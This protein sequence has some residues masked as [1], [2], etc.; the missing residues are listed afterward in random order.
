MK[1]KYLFQLLTLFFY[2]SPLVLFAQPEFINPIPIPPVLDADSGVIALDMTVT[3]HKFNPNGGGDSLNG[4]NQ[5]G[6]ESW[7]YNKAGE[8]SNTYLGPTLRWHTGDS[9]HIV[10]NNLLPDSTTTHWHGAELPA[11]LD[12]GPH[13][14]IAPGASWYVDIKDLDST[15]TIWYHP[16]LHNMTYEQVQRGLSG[17]IISEQRVDPVRDLLPRTYGVDDIPVIIGDQLTTDTI[18]PDYV[19]EIQTAKSKRPINLVN[20]VTNPYLELPAHVVRLRILNGSSRKAIEFGISDSYSDTALSALQEFYLVASDGGYALKPDTMTRMM[21]GPGERSEIIVDLSGKQVG[22]TV[23][24]RNLKEYLPNYV[25]GSPLLPPQ[26]SGAGG[27]TGQDTTNGQAF[28][29]IR[30]IADPASYTPVTAF[31]AF[32]TTWS[33]EIADTNDIAKYRTKELIRVPGTGFTIDS[34]SYE[35]M[36]INDTVCVDTKEIWTIHNKTAIAHPFHIH[37]IFFRVLEARDSSGTLLNLDS[38]G[39]NAP[40]DDILVGPYTRVRF[41]AAFDD[42]P[43]PIEAENTYMYHCHILTHEDEMG[44]G[45]MHQFVVTNEAPCNLGIDELQEQEMLLYPN[46]A[47]KEL[48]LK[49][50]SHTP[51]EISILD[52][53]GH[54]IRTQLLAAFDGVVPITIGELSH[55]M[56]LVQWNTETGVRLQKLLID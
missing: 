13:E 48:Y 2:M 29:Q 56:Y 10:V 4:T 49:G 20:G 11:L 30:I 5:N 21:T 35:M 47:G 53:Q 12:G 18:G 22:D 55:G 25:V 17:M 3:L 28:L 51:T 9:V 38:L 32:T 37:K 39:W 1:N 36:M 27:G 19:Y 41:M 14:P 52:M 33:P 8:T 54:V 40:K 24:L 34:M 43:S 46:P 16:H 42:F 26:G 44:G 50:K 23:Y 45:M 31:T 15:S 6:I 7:C